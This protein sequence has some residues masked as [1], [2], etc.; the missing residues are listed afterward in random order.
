MVLGSSPLT[1]RIT[2]SAYPIA[3]TSSLW[4][5][6][7]REFI[8]R[9]QTSSDRIPPCEE[10][11]VGIIV[12]CA[13]CRSADTRRP[14]STLLYQPAVMAGA[15]AASRA[16]FAEE[17]FIL[18]KA[19]PLR[20]LSGQREN[21]AKQAQEHKTRA[22]VTNLAAQGWRKAFAGV[23]RAC[24]GL[25]R[26]GASLRRLAQG[27]R[28]LAP[29]GARMARACARRR[30]GG[31]RMARACAGRRRGGASPFKFEFCLSR[32]SARPRLL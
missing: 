6:D 10:P 13:P 16:S 21:D 9:F 23:A 19:Q 12:L 17:N 1:M 8:T 24:A 31:A 7:S 28:E 5:V 30:R 2:S 11:M 29:A 4:K 18:S 26:G 20:L 25:R 32:A 15:P 27:W 3:L 14:V 22:T